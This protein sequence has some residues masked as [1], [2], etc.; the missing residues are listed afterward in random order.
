[1]YLVKALLSLFIVG[2]VFALTCLWFVADVAEV[3]IRMVF[4]SESLAD[5]A[6]M[7]EQ[8]EDDDE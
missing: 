6:R 2:V 1:M 4:F 5:Q 8:K 7:I 3:G